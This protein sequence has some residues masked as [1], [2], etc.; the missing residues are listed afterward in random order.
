MPEHIKQILVDSLRIMRTLDLKYQLQS[1]VLAVEAW[2]K[3]IDEMFSADK[4]HRTITLIE[5]LQID[6]R[7]NC[8][9]LSRPAGKLPDW[10]LNATKQ[11][12]CFIC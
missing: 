7:E 6:D 2:K 10:K 11:T 9:L 3:K 4:L 1:G 8:R 5:C 12:V